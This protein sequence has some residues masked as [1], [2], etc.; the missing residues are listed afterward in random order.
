MRLK[1]QL[2]LLAVGIIFAVALVV[3]L[4]AVVAMERLVH[5]LS[6]ARMRSEL[7]WIR[8][9]MNKAHQM[10]KDTGIDSLQAYLD[11]AQQ[12]MIQEF[13][14]F[15]I[16][17]T[18][19]LYIL[20]DDG[21]ILSAPSDRQ[22]SDLGDP[23]LKS[24]VI[25][26]GIGHA[27]M[28][29]AG[30][31]STVHFVAFPEWRWRILLAISE[32]EINAER[33]RFLRIALFILLFSACAGVF[34]FAR[35]AD[36]FVRPILEL[37]EKL[38]V[39]DEDQLGHQL[40][41]KHRSDEVATLLG[42]FRKLSERLHAANE[43][44]KESEIKIQNLNANLEQRV[45]ARTAELEAANL[46]L[47]EA[48][49]Q[50]DSANLAK[51]TFLANMSHEIRTPLNGII[52]MTHLLRRGGITPV[53]ADR[54]AK[55]ET[56]SEHL[57]NTINDILD[58]SKI[59]AGKIALEE[60]L[61][62]INALLN[63]VKSILMARAQAKGLQL[64]VITDTSWPDAQGDPTRLQQALLNYVGNAIKFTD[65]GSI[66]LRAL[67]QEEGPDSM[68][69]RFEVQ[70]TGIG[71]APEA[72]P[73]L[74]AAFSQAD[75]STTRKYGG[76]GLG[77]AITQRLAELMG[78]EAGVDSMAGIGST[79]WFTA[80]LH[81]YAGQRVPVRPQFSEA[82][83]A[84]KD[85][86]TGRRILV[87]DDESVNLEVAKLMLEDIGLRVDTAQDGI[88]AIQRVSKIDYAAILMDMQMPNLDGL[89]ATRQI[90]N[91]P[92]R[93]NTPILAMTANAFVEDRARCLEAGM[94]DFI[95]KPFIP[96]VLYA[97]LLKWM[98]QPAERVGV[99]PSLRI[100]I[101]AI[102]QEHNDL[103]RELD[104]LMSSPDIYPGSDRFSMAMSEIGRHLRLHCSNEE[105]LMK[106]L[107]MPAVDLES[108]TREHH[109]ALEEYTR[110]N[111][112]LMHGKLKSRTEA[113]G[114][115]KAWIIDHMV[116]H[117]LKIRA[118]VS[119]SYRADS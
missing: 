86:H 91:L 73:R 63:N 29:I 6:E 48:K 98:E 80:R 104:L 84:L 8:G 13:R 20:A 77:L 96:E 67:K 39:M 87:V 100:G 107:G 99:D 51:S 75:S 60:T 59:E 109:H 94:N 7:S 56:S 27:E 33:N 85:R 2:N 4:A 119:E 70:D 46:K 36:G 102:D 25:Q 112:E 65:T 88:E 110:V 117:D 16:G 55:I 32:D 3:S 42:A 89:G 108:M 111:D 44:R 23:A 114:L 95:V 116:H 90:R 78:G 101:P 10:L 115:F 53:Q 58:L 66:T 105:I 74:F 21:R 71:I 12:E 103:V 82:E 40:E 118:Y 24:L 79:F 45:R 30:S 92:D 1:Q 19:R 50:A 28:M 83:H 52:G 93:R 47:N 54:L 61:V 81:K 68:L 64:L 57:L 34:V 37:S 9:E 15:R 113:L 26:D 14:D 49:L 11:Q 38:S 76:T 41:L 69:I 106:S 5:D 17:K 97:T 31:L 18:G 22:V 62:D 35:L 72:L 43:R